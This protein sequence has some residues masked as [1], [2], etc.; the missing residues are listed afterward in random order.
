MLTMNGI[1]NWH[2]LICT[3]A[4]IA[5]GCTMLLSSSPA[6]ALA[7]FKENAG[8]ASGLY[9]A[10]TFGA[11]A[12]TSALFTKLVDSTNLT[13]VS[14]VYALNAAFALIIFAVNKTVKQDAK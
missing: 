2:S 1:A 14:L 4:I 8:I 7:D 9:T 5:I 10:T 3:M 11:G 6:N 12:L 13:Q